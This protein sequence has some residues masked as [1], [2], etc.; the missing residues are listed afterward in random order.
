MRMKTEESLALKFWQI[1]DHLLDII[2]SKIILDKEA[3]M[4]EMIK[5][6]DTIDDLTKINID[7]YR[8]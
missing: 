7:E 8:K 3:I 4:A 6:D 5:D 1:V 2:I